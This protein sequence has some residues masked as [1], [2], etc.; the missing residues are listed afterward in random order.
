M[1][2]DQAEPHRLRVAIRGA[3]Q[4]VGFR[5]FV[6]RLASE[7]RL[8]GWVLNS[9][10]GVTVEV[11]GESERLAL[12][13]SRLSNERPPRAVVHGMESCFL[14][15]VGFVGFEIRESIGG[16][17]TA[18]VLPDIATCPDC[19]REVFDP[20]DRRYR[21][22][23]TN[24][25]NCGPR[26]TIV[27]AL[28]YD[29]PRT[30]MAR[31]TMCAACQAEYDD[32]LD[33]RFHAQPNACPACGPR[34]ALWDPSGVARADGDEALAGAVRALRAGRILALKGLGGFHLV[35]DARDDEAVRRLR[36]AKSR[37]EKP[38]AVMVP[39]V[40]D[41]GAAC[42][43]GDAELR[44]LASAEAP[45]VLL[46]KRG[47]GGVS[48]GVAPGNPC[49]GVML[50]YTPLHHLL[51]S[52]FGGPV[53]ATSG[54][55]ADEPICTDEREALARLRGLADVFLVHD[56]PIARHADDSVVRVV[57]GRELMIRRARGF[58]PMP[59]PVTASDGSVLAV[60]AQL[61]NSVA[62]SVGTQAFVSQHIGDLE[63]PEA[64]GAFEEVIG[65][66]R[67]I[68]EARPA[69]VA[70]DAHPNYLSTT[71]ARR[72][73]LPVAAVQHHVAHVF[74]CMAE[75][76]ATPPALGV[77]WDGTGYGLD[78]TIWGGEFFSVTSQAVHR[79]ATLE[80][81]GLP[82]GDQ[83]IR[84]PRRTA[85]AILYRLSGDSAFDQ[86]DLAPIRD[87]SDTERQV[88]RRM[89]E[90]GLNTPAT[91]SVGRLFDGVAAL[92]G[93]RQRV[94]YEGQAAMELEF[95]VDGSDEGPAYPFELSAAPDGSRPAVLDWRP[96]LAAIVADIRARTG[97]GAVAARFHRTL[98]EMIVAVAVSQG[99]RQVVLSGGCFQN[100]LL[101]ELVVTRLREE[102]F[103]PYWHQRL[104]PNDGG[105]A[106]GQIA[107]VASGI[108]GATVEQ[109]TS[110][111]VRVR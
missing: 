14:D 44:L 18:L 5:P 50:P 37:E 105:I 9:A 55:R 71:F 72:L 26:F 54:N 13:L 62:L 24:C 89:L 91:S 73:G 23:F 17:K 101:T 48:A 4:G 93:L 7:L 8:P 74:A 40:A 70:C 38:F 27:R 69:L 85:A 100:R 66:L 102:G 60:G 25:T 95:A 77:A 78:G 111:G 58:A 22:P 46:D 42:L 36:A 108:P 96:M 3:V 109:W 59:F 47:D 29:R 98:A 51:L 10:A 1:D 61:K 68:Y 67:G 82:G 104:P 79:V 52:D 88:L 39:G 15:P 19:R 92:L 16:E 49:L 63:T 110:D 99:I 90:G 21:Y 94:R 64:F 2:H 106:L 32:P 84:E 83:A 103:R 81:F 12:F 87:L 97:V 80:P 33:R 30:T 45:I 53:V 20:A 31:F 11:E 43:V 6:Y 34:L 75:N 76:Q 57:L 41:A 107:A 65:A 56:R 86:L 35:V 28:P